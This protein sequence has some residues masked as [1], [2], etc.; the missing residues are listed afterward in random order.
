[1]SVQPAST[2]RNQ[3][4]FTAET[5]APARLAA[6]RAYLD[7]EGA[8]IRLQHQDGATG[9]KI[10]QA[11][12]DRMDGLLVPLFTTAIAA[13]RNQHGEP[14][15]P[16]CLVALG[17]Y[18]RAE[19]N[20]LSDVDVMFLYPEAGKTPAL[21]QF[22]EH[23]SNGILYPLWDL[24]LKIGH[25]TRTLSEVFAEAGREIKTKTALL[26]A[27]FLAGTT[28][29]F[30][31]FA[32]AYRKH[33]LQSDPKAY[34]VAR[35]EDQAS[36]RAQHGDTVFLQEPDIKNGVGGLRDYQNTLWMARVR[37]GITHLDDLAQQN[38]LQ[39]AELRAMQDAYDFLLRVR[40]ELHYMSKHPTDVLNLEIQ[41]RLAA[42]LGYPQIGLLERV[43]AFM[44]DYYRHAQ[45]IFRISRIVEQRLAL[46]VATGPGLVGSL[47]NLMLARRSE[48]TKRI[49]G[50]LIR[51]REL[52]YENRDIFQQDPVRLIRVFRHCQQLGCTPDLDLAS[53]I[54][55]SGQLI[56]QQVIES[57]DANLAFQTILE[58]AGQ[59]YPTLSLMH[60]LGVL[61][62]FMPEFAPLTCLVQHEYYHRYTADIH[63]LS[64]IRQLDIIFT[65]SDPRAEKYRE[66]LHQTAKP[67]LLYLILLLHDIGKSEG[68]QGHA[69]A[70][71]TVAG[72]VLD[73][74]GV[75]SDTR[76]TVNFIIKNHLI[77]AR[78]WQKHDLDDP[79]SSAA[80]AELVGDAD[81]LRYLYVHTYCDANGTSASLWNSYKDSLHRRLFD[82]T[83]ERL[84]LG[85]KVE[86][87]LEERKEMIRQDL[88][89]RTIPGI[90]PDEIT[91]HFN[92]LPERYFIQTDETEI[93]L[94]I[95]MVNRLLQ[96]ISTADSLSPLRPVIEW[97]DDLNR[98][99]TTVHVVTWDRAG[100]FY[101]L[102]G[103]FSVAGLSIL[104]ARI[105][106]RADHIAID[107]FHIVEP[108][109][110][111]V[112]N[113]K[114]M[115][116][117]ARTVDDALVSDK[118]L[119]PEI[120]AQAARLANANRYKA[121]ASELPATFP[122]TVEVY[123]ELSLKRIIVE[124]QAHDRIGLLYQLVKTISDH[125]FDI[126]FAR[127]NTE[128]SIALDTFYIEPQKT[129]APV[130]E[131]ELHVLRDTLRVLIT[132]TKTE[133]TG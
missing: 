61:G 116:T 55:G 19:L 129:E 120:N 52:A 92:L 106:T 3:P 51:G 23:L 99:Y 46:T 62:R 30:D 90:S 80:F 107:T 85:D 49:D 122:P 94:H 125:G 35:L 74:L 105:T 22:Q 18:G 88:I 70:G 26:E 78:F 83:L 97:K 53:L 32:D 29:L 44:Q 10:V 82:T 54:R 38:Y 63:T 57:R 95:Q 67:T 39:P 50:F 100:L 111:I 114:A 12:S 127:I 42:A 1:M 27:R 119:L 34:I 96:S 101:K 15:V 89:A 110:G 112:Q 43:E 14:P 98:S 133:A 121:G 103:A 115:E 16:V 48:R 109:R 47:K 2:N 56:T 73:R 77:M 65:A 17:G 7:E 91:A 66:V 25:S 130:E 84:V 123:H 31:N 37:L 79:K 60:E 58:E 36:R 113:Q 68:I 40:N 13:W 20:P 9:R 11:L 76:A 72:P 45:A 71:V 41:P 5:P 28:T 4:V 132:P 93:T 131:S 118:D 59:V 126:T 124:I 104:S 117:F 6:C 33:Y 108:G 69:E 64:T 81:Q 8:R 21:A 24:K 75:P 86:S 128:R 102:A 87:R